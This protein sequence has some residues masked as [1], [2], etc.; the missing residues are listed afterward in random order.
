MFLQGVPI[1]SISI[2]PIITLW[3]G[4]DAA[5]L[6]KRLSNA[7]H[8]KGCSALLQRRHP[9]PMVNL[10]GTMC[11]V[12][13]G[14]YF[15]SISLVVVAM[16]YSNERCHRNQCKCMKCLLQEIVRPLSIEFALRVMYSSKPF[17]IDGLHVHTTSCYGWGGRMYRNCVR[18]DNKKGGGSCIAISTLF[19]SAFIYMVS[20][21]AV[22]STSAGW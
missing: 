19:D 11:K 18:E 14:V 16:L 4:W 15:C 9:P 3:R 17:T 10:G 8:K 12:S 6:K 20:T 2:L 5:L 21:V 1:F 7:I 22:K 13:N